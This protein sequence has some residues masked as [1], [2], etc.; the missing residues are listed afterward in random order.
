M[1][2][3]FLVDTA[4]PFEQT[5]A[6]LKA[7]LATHDF[8]LLAIHDLATTL[9]SKTIAFPENCRAFEVCNPQPA[10]AERLQWPALH[11][12]SSPPAMGERAAN[13]S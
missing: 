7:A 11:P 8:G 9:R 4:T 10:A 12:P 13:S 6:N 2:P 3:A 5:C 1:S